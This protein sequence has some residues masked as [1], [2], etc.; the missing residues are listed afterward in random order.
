[1]LYQKYTNLFLDTLVHYVLSWTGVIHL[2]VNLKHILELMNF[3]E[4]F[5]YHLINV[6][7]EQKYQ[8]YLTPNVG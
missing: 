8:I 7:Q 3:C 4:I 1:M 5:L 2:I 6:L